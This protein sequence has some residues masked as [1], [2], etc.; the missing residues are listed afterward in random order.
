M[1]LTGLPAQSKP[2]PAPE[3]E[4]MRAGMMWHGPL[5]ARAGRAGVSVRAKLIS[6]LVGSSLLTAVAL[7]AGAFATSTAIVGWGYNGRYD[8]GAGYRDGAGNA[9]IQPVLGL[10]DVKT[11][12]VAGSSSYAVMPDE[13]IRAWG[14]GVKGNLGDGINRSR[15]GDPIS[16]ARW[17]V[18]VLE[19]NALG[20]RKPLGHVKQLAASYGAFTH[21]LALVENPEHEMEVFTWGASE[22]GERGNGEY[23]FIAPKEEESHAIDP[24][25]V[26]MATVPL[27][28][29]VYVAAGGAASF[30]IT[31][32]GGVTKVWGW[33][34]DMGGRLGVV[35]G[36]PTIQCDGAGGL[37]TCVTEPAEIAIPAL[38]PGVKVTAL[39]TGRNATFALLS[40]RQVL[41][42]GENTYGQ[43]GN[44][45]APAAGPVPSYV[46]AVR[47]TAPCSAHL[48]HVV[49]VDGGWNSAVALRKGGTVVGWGSN[50][51]GQLGRKAVEAKVPMKIKGL[52]KIKQ[53]SEG[54]ATT[55]ALTR[56][57]TVEALGVNE[58]G[59]LGNGTLTGPEKCTNVFITAE[60]PTEVVVECSR[61]PVAVAGLSGVGGISAGVSEFKEGHALAWL[62]SGSAPPPEFTVTPGQDS[63]TIN[64]TFASEEFKI[65]YRVAPELETET[66]E[67][68]K[69]V[70]W[71]VGPKT[72]PCSTT[73]TGLEAGQ[74]YEV[75]VSSLA[76]VEGK[77]KT[78]DSHNA[79]ATPEG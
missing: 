48:E 22:Y 31:E 6:M 56:A 46:C 79:F 35:A 53:V 50:E 67:T 3:E 68:E 36:T 52:K 60:G 13:T 15:E 7:P 74:Q 66:E 65:A 24:R 51:D 69:W 37:Q 17:P 49:E 42:W 61:S 28:H 76:K 40:N 2:C 41:A 25:E 70:R 34:I 33:G 78:E 27:K 16:T 14:G 43:L 5:G 62:T 23:G 45:M 77:Q 20:E 59:Q 18:T 44:G 63:I 58:H 19:Q 64:W 30:A 71:E 21:A 32:E 57:G 29:V 38:P 55:F 9:S 12:L 1:T 39:A 75:K 26:A 10:T 54:A 72:C 47:A 73:I 8:L 11:V 4:A